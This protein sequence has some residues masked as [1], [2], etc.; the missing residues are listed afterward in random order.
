MRLNKHLLCDNGRI[1][2]R[3]TREEVFLDFVRRVRD[4]FRVRKD[5]L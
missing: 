5:F 2:Q 4:E 1:P 3:I